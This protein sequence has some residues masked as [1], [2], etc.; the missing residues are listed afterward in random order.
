MSDQSRFTMEIYPFWA[1]IYQIKKQISLNL[2]GCQKSFIESAEITASEL[3]ENAI[4]YGGGMKSDSKVG[5]EMEVNEEKAKITVTNTVGSKDHIENFEKIMNRIRTTE[6]RK[7]LYV[8]RLKEIL[9]N[10]H[11][12]KC[13]LGLYRLALDSRYELKYILNNEKLILIAEAELPNN[14]SANV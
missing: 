6:N 14:K 4:K 10:P 7:S 3:L 1:V 8:Q 12:S 13:E 2:K 9:E 5:F 11:T